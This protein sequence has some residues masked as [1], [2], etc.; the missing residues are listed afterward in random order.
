MPVQ[1]SGVLKDG[2]GKPVP[3]CTIELKAVRTS[4]TVIV[5]TVAEHQPGETGSYSMQVEPGRYRVTLCV[6]G[7]QPAYA[8]E[9]DVMAD[10]KPGTLNA[11][12]LRETDAAYYPDA[13]KKL[14]AAADEAVRRAREAAEKA[15]TAVGPQGPK[16]DKGEKGEQGPKGDKGDT[17]AQGPK[18]ETGAKGDKGDTG[19]AGPKG[20]RGDPGGPQGPKGDTGA[21]GPAGPQGP[22]GDT[23]ATGPAGPQGPKGDTGAT[24][25]AGPQGPKGDTGAT[26]PA[27]PQGPKGDTGATGPAG[28]QGPKGDTGATGPAGPQGPKGDTGATGPAGPQ[29][30]KGDTGATGP[31]GPQGPAGSSDSGLFGVGSFVLAAYYPTSYQGDMPPGTTVAGSSLSA[32]CLSN[33]TPLIASDNVGET[34]LPGTWRACGP[35]IWTSS[36]GIRQAGLFQRIS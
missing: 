28:S 31:A 22:K 27:G 33:G 19:P 11:F 24:G 4:E 25:P 23:G 9:I 5:T 15:E 3:E 36:V 12:L 10:D 1:I 30:P 20:E 26:G 34:R 18:G 29:G 7:R 6:E 14:E 35:L 13:L 16:G 8:G 32:C 21:A 17:G 2:T